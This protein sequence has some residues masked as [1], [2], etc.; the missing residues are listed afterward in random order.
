MTHSQIDADGGR[1]AQPSLA[2]KGLSSSH[3]GLPTWPELPYSMATVFQGQETRGQQDQTPERAHQGE[4]SQATQHLPHSAPCVQAGTSAH[5]GS[6]GGDTL[7][8]L[9]REQEHEEQKIFLWP[10]LG[11]AVYTPP[12]YTFGCPAQQGR[13][14]VESQSFPYN[15]EDGKF[16]YTSD[17]VLRWVPKDFGNERPVCWFPIIFFKII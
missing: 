5:S 11:N 7:F 8:P 4:A 2:A 16:T 12:K 9:R 1:V 13:Y 10:L 17:P 3:T 15:L 6:R 14:L